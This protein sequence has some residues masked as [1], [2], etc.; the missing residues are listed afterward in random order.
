[1]SLL[2]SWR[3][4]GN[5]DMVSLNDIRQSGAEGIVHALH[6]VPVGEVWNYSSIMERKQQI[7]ETNKHQ[8]Y[9]LEWRVA[10]SLNVHE[11]IR[12][13]LP[14]RDQFIV[15]YIQS[16]KNLSKA[17]IKTVCYNFMPLLDWTR[18][19]LNYLMPDGSHALR[20]EKKA[21]IAFDLFILKRKEAQFEY[22]DLQKIK[23]EDFYK[24]LDQEKIEK[25]THNILQGVPGS[26]LVHS[27]TD[28]KKLLHKYAQIDREILRENLAYFL[29]EVVPVAEKVGVKLCCHPDDPPFSLFG[30]PRI[31][32]TYDDIEY[33]VNCTQS[34]SNGITFCTGS[35]GARLDNNLVEIVKRFAKNIHFVHLRNVAVESDGSFH[36]SSHLEGS[37]DM[38]E[39]MK[40]LVIESERRKNEEQIDYR[41]P[42]RPD[43]GHQ[44]LDDLQKK[45]P[46]HGYSAIGRLR[47]LAEL[48]GL[49]LGIRKSIAQ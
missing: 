36:E 33:L 37:V 44:M 12:Q 16:L 42:Y 6:E 19:D 46:F 28:F 41:I 9:S 24:G 1:M 32:S 39:I 20:F 49:E 25:L 34:S 8:K 35:L 13:A 17:G 14:D 5:N 26:Q 45:I 10:E 48:R 11:S 22:S 30:I 31:V 15:N 2:Q 18:T 27:L 29:Q 4:Y 3:W 47:G 40:Q 7:E 38:Y 23:A 21:C 43:H